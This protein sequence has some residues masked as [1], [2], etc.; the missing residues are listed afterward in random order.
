MMLVVLRRLVP[1]EEAV[2][3]AGPLTVLNRSEV[4]V[5]DQATV[6]AAVLAVKALKKKIYLDLVVEEGALPKFEGVTVLPGATFS[7]ARYGTLLDLGTD[8]VDGRYGA[9]HAQRHA[10]RISAALRKGAVA[11]LASFSS[12][13]IFEAESASLEDVK[14][15]E[16][17]LFRREKHLC[18]RPR[19]RRSYERIK[20]ALNVSQQDSFVEEAADVVFTL[21]ST[22]YEPWVEPFRQWMHEEQEHSFVI[23]IN[24]IVYKRMRRWKNMTKYAQ[25]FAS[26]LSDV[27]QAAPSL[28]GRN[29][30][31]VLIHHDTRKNRLGIN[32]MTESHLYQEIQNQFKNMRLYNDGLPYFASDSR[33]L[34]ADMDMVFAGSM[35][36]MI[37]AASVY[38]P[39][40]GMGGQTKHIELLRD[41]YSANSTAKCLSQESIQLDEK[42]L[43]DTSRPFCWEEKGC[44]NALA[45]SILRGLHCRAHLRQDLRASVPGL[46]D[47]AKRNLNALK[48][49]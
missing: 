6:L 28:L 43:H 5:G 25:F 46:V 20:R 37:L 29:V 1:A 35:H 8:V 3:I 33:S 17:I 34:L 10:L 24:A 45:Y 38:T 44:F 40:L 11:T 48:G 7:L 39:V 14:K 19:N 4:N 42:A 21:P 15:A 49:C 16:S 23:G 32:D 2:V 41:L 18:F 31:F 9:D 30:S 12:E 13:G 22:S 36:L 26:E 47:K 27:A